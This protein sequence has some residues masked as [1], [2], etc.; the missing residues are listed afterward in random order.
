MNFNEKQSG[1]KVTVVIMGIERIYSCITKQQPHTQLSRL[2]VGCRRNWRDI[3]LTNQEIH[4]QFQ[5]T[6]PTSTCQITVH[7]VQC[8]GKVPSFILVIKCEYNT[9]FIILLCFL[10][11]SLRELM[12]WVWLGIHI[13][14]ELDLS[15]CGMINIDNIDIRDLLAFVFE[16][17]NSIFR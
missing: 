12:L 7:G 16:T 5:H 9:F 14:L 10:F 11:I 13:N 4:S 8:I 1:I 6:D 15:L 3:L 2:N 17:L